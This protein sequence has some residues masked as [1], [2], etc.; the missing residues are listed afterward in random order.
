MT[1]RQNWQA[2][3][4]NQARVDWAAYQK[5]RLG[6]WPEC[7]QLLFL[8]MASEKLGKA[9]LIA[10]PSNLETITQSHAA[11]VMF[12]RFAGN[13]HKLQK[14]L[15]L[16]KSQQRAQ[17]KSLLPLAHEIELLAPALAQG[18]PNPEYPWQNT[19]GDIFAPT[20]YPFPLIQRLHQTP[21]G[22]QLLKY[23]EIFLKRFEELF[24]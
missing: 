18:G 17:F 4:L 19:S 6:T 12:M 16:K 11:F 10:G 14:M 13:N 21:Q 20:N 23:V 5:T 7:H 1:D 2:A 22:I 3:F 24:M 15:G 8:Q 9:V